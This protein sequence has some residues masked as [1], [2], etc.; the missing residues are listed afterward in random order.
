MTDVRIRI[1]KSGA[2]GAPSTEP[3]TTVTIPGKILEVA[4]KLIPKRAI[5]ALHEEGIDI[6]E[7]VQLTRNPEVRGT[8]VEIENHQ[9]GERVVI[10]L[11]QREEP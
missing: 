10:S 11:E 3:Q 8:V 7:L 9:K 5:S 6:D 4:S 1:Y 2:G